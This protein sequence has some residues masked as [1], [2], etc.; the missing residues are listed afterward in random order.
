LNQDIPL[1]IVLVPAQR[2]QRNER[3]DADK[4]DDVEEK[5]WHSNDSEC[6]GRASRWFVG[7]LKKDGRGLFCKKHNVFAALF[8]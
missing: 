1:Q 3:R 4:Q 5:Y 6:V 7:R 2:R 8:Q